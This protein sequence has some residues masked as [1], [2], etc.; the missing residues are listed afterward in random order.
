MLLARLLSCFGVFSPLKKYVEDGCPICLED[1]KRCHFLQPCG[2][3]L[4]DECFLQW[5][6]HHPERP[7]RCV[8]CQT[9]VHALLMNNVW[10]PFDTWKKKA[11]ERRFQEHFMEGGTLYLLVDEKTLRATIP[12]S[13]T[14]KA[15]KQKVMA[16]IKSF[17]EKK[18]ISR[19]LYEAL[20]YF[21]STVRLE[22]LREEHCYE[23]HRFPVLGMLG[24]AGPTYLMFSKSTCALLTGS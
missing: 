6:L 24:M 8:L 20:R 22:H 3:L 7:P 13:P 15:W 12:P 16:S 2:H 4:H 11:L 14:V 17:F 23:V 5:C 10:Y 9:K 1:D 19:L 21:I 18:Q